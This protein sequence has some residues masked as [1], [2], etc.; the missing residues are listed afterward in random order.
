[1]AERDL[2]VALVDRLQAFLLERGHGFAFVARQYRFLVDGDVFSIDLLFYNRAQS[3]SV[4]VELKIGRFTPKYAGQ[5]GVYVAWVDAN[6]RD[7]QRHSPTVGILLC[8]GRNDQVVRYALAG[9]PAP[10]AVADYTYNALPACRP[11]R[12][13]H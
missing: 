6:L 9:A 4:V 8:A 10:L 3:R 13:A 7:P 11:G 1:M 5:L 2:E 12:R